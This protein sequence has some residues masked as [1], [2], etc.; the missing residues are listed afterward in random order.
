MGLSAMRLADMEDYIQT[1]Y[2]LLRKETIEV[3][4]E[5]SLR[6]IRFLNPDHGLINTDDPIALH[7]SAYGPRS[8]ALTAK[9]QAG[10]LC[11]C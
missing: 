9:L 3:T 8:R 7:V 10:W 11:Q 2:A 1:I 6:K 4:L 5:G